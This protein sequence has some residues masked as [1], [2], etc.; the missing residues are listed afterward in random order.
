MSRTEATAVGSAVCETYQA[1][2]DDCANARRQ[3]NER[4]AEISELGLRGKGID[5]ELLGLQARFAK[6]YAMVRNHVCDCGS[7]QLAS[8]ADD[9]SRHE[10]D[11]PVVTEFH[12]S[13]VS[14]SRFSHV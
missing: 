6:S 7:C 13:F 9:A 12:A 2:I 8:G 1:L 3:W 10:G 11:A 5:N 14:G 4:R